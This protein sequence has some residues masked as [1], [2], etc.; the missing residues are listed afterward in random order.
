M[1]FNI[2]IN[3]LE[4]EGTAS[5]GIAAAPTSN[6]GFL[7]RSERGI[8]NQAQP[9]RGLVDYASSFG[10]PTLEAYGAHVLRGFFENGGALA[11]VARVVGAGAVPAEQTLV[12]RLGADTLTVR[13][14]QRGQADPGP[15]GSQLEV[16]VLDHPR[17]TS[18]VP[19]Q[20]TGAEAEPFALADG[21]TLGLLVDGATTPVTVT[22][23]ATDFGDIAAATAAEVVAVLRRQA[24]T[25]RATMTPSLELVLAS[26]ISG[27]RSRVEIVA[28]AA[29]TALGFTGATANSDA[30]L[31]AGTELVLADS[32]GGIVTGS[33]L[34]IQTRAY[35]VGAA[36]IAASITDGASILVTVNGGPAVEVTFTDADF[37]GGAG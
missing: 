5:P 26:S 31:G 8:P 15:W 3:V 21:Q 35:V 27:P 4:V 18:G 17:A 19:A 24:P 13:A 2:G 22:F 25:V 10:R 16:S 34:R 14:G 37:S 7:I 30:G 29:A 1:A 28:S 33:A 12:D 6:A 32:V 36:P 20:I 23:A 9:V 11:Y